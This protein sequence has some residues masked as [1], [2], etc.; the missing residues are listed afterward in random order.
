MCSAVNDISFGTDT[1]CIEYWENHLKS[2][3]VK[4]DSG[5]GVSYLLLRLLGSE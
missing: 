5:K 4:A 1:G 2:G 3:G